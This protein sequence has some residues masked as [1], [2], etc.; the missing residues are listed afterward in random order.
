MIQRPLNALFVMLLAA[1]QGLR[2]Q[3]EKLKFKRPWFCTLGLF[4]DND[5]G[6]VSQ[7]MP[8]RARP[9]L[10]SEME[11][12][13]GPRKGPETGHSSRHCGYT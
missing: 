7:G 8:D 12:R 4:W 13:T 6:Y 1:R 3:E 5:K 10:I 2:V 9:W 11:H